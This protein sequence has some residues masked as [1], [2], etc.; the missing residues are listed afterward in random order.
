[1]SNEGVP[2]DESA[3]DRAHRSMDDQASVEEK[4]ANRVKTPEELENEAAVRR[5]EISGSN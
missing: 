4:H 5:M 3:E 1:M 2:R